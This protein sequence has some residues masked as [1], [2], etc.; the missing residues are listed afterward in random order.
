MIV[1]EFLSNIP[2]LV[3][4][5]LCMLHVTYM[6]DI[7]DVYMIFTC[8]LQCCLLR[9]CRLNPTTS[10]GKTNRQVCRHLLHAANAVQP[11]LTT[12]PRLL[13]PSGQA[14]SPCLRIPA[15]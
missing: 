6:A 14:I 1:I 3:R 12:L 13:M 5:S 7:H 15:L 4:M 10:W 8:G 2:G 11:L 9:N